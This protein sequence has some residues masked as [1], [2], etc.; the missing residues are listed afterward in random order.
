MAKD[1]RTEYANDFTS[2]NER[3]IGVEDYIKGMVKGGLIR[4]LIVNGPPGVGKT[5]SVKAYLDIHI[6]S[7]NYKLMNGH[8]TLLSL[9]AKLYDFRDSGKVV[10]LDDVDSVFSKTD[11]LNILKA[12]MD[13]TNQRVIHWE[14]PTH[15]LTTMEVPKSFEYNGSVILISNIG[16]GGVANKLAAH[17]NALKDRSYYSHIGHADVESSFKQICYMVIEKDIFTTLGVPQEHHMMLLEYIDE[18]KKRFTTLSLRTVVKLST[19]FT[20]NSKDWKRMAN[21][22]MLKV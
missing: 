2:L 6:G 11:G 14:S 12:A 20:M 15:L 4:S 21:Q 3:Y 7:E 16:F 19:I 13:T 1:Y 8:C 5:H 18:N 22:G 17:L 10:V 9:Y